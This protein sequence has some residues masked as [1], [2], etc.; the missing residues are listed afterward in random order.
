MNEKDVKLT[1]RRLFGMEARHSERL[2][3]TAS[4]LPHET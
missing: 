2:L 4:P 3:M 1:R